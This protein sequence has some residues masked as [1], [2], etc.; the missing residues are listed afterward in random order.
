MN[1]GIAFS[2]PTGWPQL[3]SIAPLGATDT[4]LTDVVVVTPLPHPA[5]DAPPVVRGL[6]AL[7]VPGDS[8]R[9]DRRFKLQLES[10]ERGA[11]AATRRALHAPRSCLRTRRKAG[12]SDIASTRLRT[13]PT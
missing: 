7:P 5:A 2:A 12:G 9:R 6:R 13:R 10:S 11:P 8:Q 1:D 4:P 3:F